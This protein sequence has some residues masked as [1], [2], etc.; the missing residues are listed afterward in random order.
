MHSNLTHLTVLFAMPRLQNLMKFICRIFAVA[1]FACILS[2]RGQLVDGIKVVVDDALVTHVDVDLDMLGRGAVE[3][4]QRQYSR[5]P[6]MF[7]KKLSEAETDSLQR[8]LDRR[9]ILHEFKSLKVPET[10]LDSEVDREIQQEI[11]SRYMDRMTLQKT[12][13]AEGIT[14]E[15]HRKQIRERIIIGFLS[16]KNV[17]SEVI[18]SPH[19]VEAFY[20][21]HTNDF[22][23]NDEVKLR[24]IVLTNTPSL[25]A[26]QPKKLAEEIVAKLK[27]GAEFG[28]LASVYSQVLQRRE[29][30]EWSER[31]I[32]RKEIADAAFKLKAGEY[33]DVIETPDA[34]YIILVEDIKSSHM[35]S[36]GEVR[37]QIE[38]ALKLEERAR[39]EKLW[40]AKL[41]KKTFVR[42]F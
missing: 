42:Y 25:E 26:P 22:T 2:A 18:I 9:L 33:S 5:E 38:T 40:L 39:L 4:L 3:S 30:G 32:L 10:I 36:L 13:Q 8:L 11:Q 15:A 16:H 24:M 19:K 31:A 1:S 6:E 21:A 7:Q 28:Q 34:C 35:K 20:M 27:E 41:K 23:M 17:A 12:L 37:D 14:Y 29:K